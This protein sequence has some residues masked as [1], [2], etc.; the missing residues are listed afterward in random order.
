MSVVIKSG[1]GGGVCELL[2]ES[3]WIELSESWN[4]FCI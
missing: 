2:D 4:N 1:E 3:C